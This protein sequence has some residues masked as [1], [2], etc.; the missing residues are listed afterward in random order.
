MMTVNEEK[1]NAF[2]GKMLDDVGAAMNASL[3]LLG[4][5]SGAC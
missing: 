2:L 3:M 1:L 5:M 4:D